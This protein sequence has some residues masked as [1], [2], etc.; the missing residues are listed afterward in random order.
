[1]GFRVVKGWRGL[2]L[3]G[4]SLEVLK[5][6]RCMVTSF[7]TLCVGF[8]FGFRAFLRS[9]AFLSFRALLGCRV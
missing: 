3:S 1:M 7:S 2:G 4:Q 6:F 5:G 8:L 9:R